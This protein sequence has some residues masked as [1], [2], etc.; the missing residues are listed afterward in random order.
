MY[1]YIYICVCICICV[2]AHI[3]MYTYIYIYIERERE[4]ETYQYFFLEHVTNK[5]RPAI[6]MFEPNNLRE[7]SNRTPPTSETHSGARV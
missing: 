2:Y 4:R 1:I 5:L 7:V 3:R 6:G